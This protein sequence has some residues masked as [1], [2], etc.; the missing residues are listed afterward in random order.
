MIAFEKIDLTPNLDQSRKGLSQKK[1]TTKKQ[2]NK[3]K[4]NKSKK[5]KIDLQELNIFKILAF[6]FAFP[7][8]LK[9]I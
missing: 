4:Q 1:T 9:C 8:K 6:V 5:H 2:K 3:T 7:V